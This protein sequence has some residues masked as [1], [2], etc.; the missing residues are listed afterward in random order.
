MPLYTNGQVNSIISGNIPNIITDANTGAQAPVDSVNGVTIKGFGTS[1]AVI[2]SKFGLSS[3]ATGQVTLT[4]TSASAIVAA[5]TGVP[6]VG[7]GSITLTNTSTTA[8]Y[9]GNSG[10]T[11]STGLLLSGIVG[12]SITLDTTAA[13]YGCL[14][15]G[16]SA[17][18]SFCEVF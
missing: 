4:T 17:T 2:N 14:A 3:L 6:G 16:G 5:R 18:V 7:R 8:V 9:L 1:N 13:I 12:A 10:V 15:A 11:F